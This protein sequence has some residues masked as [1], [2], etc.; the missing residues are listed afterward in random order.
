RLDRTRPHDGRGLRRTPVRVHESARLGRRPRHLGDRAGSR[1]RRRRGGPCQAVDRHL[2]PGSRRSGRRANRQGRR[3]SSPRGARSG[4]RTRL[5]SPLLPGSTRLPGLRRDHHHR[6][7]RPP[8][9]T[10][11]AARRADRHQR[12]CR[13]PVRTRRLGTRHQCRWPGRLTRRRNRTGNRGL[14]RAV[15]LL[16]RQQ[17]TRTRERTNTVALGAGIGAAVV[18]LVLAAGFLLANRS[19]NRQRDAL[20]TARA[21]LAATPSHRVSAQTNAFRSSIL[22][23]REQRS[24]ALAAAIGKRVAWDRILRRMTLV[25]PDD[26]WLTT[27]HGTMPLQSAAP[28]G[29]PTTAA[30]TST[31]SALPPTPTALTI[32]GYTYSQAGVARLMERLQVLPDLK[33]VQLTTSV[34]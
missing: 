26:V 32:T 17:V 30:T 14:M 3:G 13:R 1:S 18:V 4:P 6:R 31:S 20:S 23:Q 24:L 28:V 8:A 7:R 22:N 9:G 29:T 5:L 34:K 27:V 19:E 2:E 11:R 21:V 25:L 15:N 33:N 12:Q 10:G 16:P